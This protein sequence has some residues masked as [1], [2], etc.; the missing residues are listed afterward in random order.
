M[1][2]TAS[3]FTTASI[4]CFYL[5][6]PHGDNFGPMHWGHA[7]SRELE[8]CTH[9]PTALHPYEHGQIYNGSVVVDWNNSS[10]LGTADAPP[11]VA[12]YT[13]HHAGRE[14]GG[15][16]DHQTQALALSLQKLG[17]VW[18]VPRR[19]HIWRRIRDLVQPV[20]PDGVTAP[21]LA[22]RSAELK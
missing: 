13:C 11:L 17:T 6:N 14:Q 5:H 4:T 7:V 12:I 19:T 20:C 22:C 16:G 8:N 21:S 18:L 3:S 10:G 15:R 1:I 2:R 9:L